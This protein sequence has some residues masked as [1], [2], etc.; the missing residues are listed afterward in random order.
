MCV[1]PEL[2]TLANNMSEDLIFAIAKDG[3]DT[4]E[5]PIPKE[6]ILLADNNDCLGFMEE[7]YVINEKYPCLYSTN[8]KY[9][10]NGAK[11]IYF[12][13]EL[14]G[15]FGYPNHM[16]YV[17]KYLAHLCASLKVDM[18][19]N[20]IEKLYRNNIYNSLVLALNKTNRPAIALVNDI[21]NFNEDVNDYIYD[22]GDF[23]DYRN[24]NNDTGDYNDI[25]YKIQK[26]RDLID[27]NP[28]VLRDY[29][30]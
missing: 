30:K 8:S 12:Y 20:S 14:N 24:E 3:F 23:Y 22:H 15:D 11:I 18:E 16:R 28:M 1:R 27:D 9:R 19:I 10:L 5:M 25:D 21:L 29:A 26:L 13:R 2:A 6:S 7:D 17:F 4:Y